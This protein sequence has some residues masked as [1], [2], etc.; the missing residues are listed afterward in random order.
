MSP[1]MHGVFEWAIL[2]GTGTLSSAC[3]LVGRLLFFIDAR[4]GLS[5][6][7][8]LLWRAV[9]TLHAQGEDADDDMADALAAEQLPHIPA[10]D[11]AYLQSTLGPFPAVPD[12][13]EGSRSAYGAD[14]VRQAT[15][16]R[17]NAVKRALG[18]ASGLCKAFKRPIIRAIRNRTLVF[19]RDPDTMRVMG[20]RVDVVTRS[21]SAQPV[22]T[23][24][25]VAR[26]AK[27]PYIKM[28]VAPT[29]AE[30]IELFTL[31]SDQATPTA[32]LAQLLLDER[33]RGPQPQR[34]VIL[35]GMPGTGKS[36][37]RPLFLGGE[38]YN[39]NDVMTV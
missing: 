15:P 22:T 7:T 36:Q 8:P 9:P 16:G 10:K 11:P 20:A 23:S 29:I 39:L 32:Y 1:L 26:G 34:R 31:S 6:P 2:V 17:A 12:L 30:T 38:A 35:S 13:G 28:A 37:A 27:P 18:A 3:L 5:P 4:Q 19:D 25:P 14:V 21:P 24:E 33:D